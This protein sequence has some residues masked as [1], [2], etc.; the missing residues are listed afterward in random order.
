MPTIGGLGAISAID[1]TAQIPVQID[2]SNAYVTPSQ[3]VAAGGGGAGTITSV[4][5]D[6]GPAVTLD[7]ADVGA[8]SDP[9][10]LSGV[11]GLTGAEILTVE[12]GGTP[13]QA[14]TQ[15][16][17]NLAG[18]GSAVTSVNGQ[19]GPTVTLDAGDVGATPDPQLLSGVSGLTG[20]ERVAVLQGSGMVQATTAQ[21]AA[22]SGAVPATAAAGTVFA[23]PV[24]G[25]PAAPAFRDL[26]WN[27]DLPLYSSVSSTSGLDGDEH[28]LVEKGSTFL[29]TTVLALSRALLNFVNVFT[30]N[31]SVRTVTLTDAATVATDASLSNNFEVTL[32]GNRTLGN[33]TNLTRGMQLTWIVKQDGTGGR[34]L[35]YGN[36]F[37]WPS[38][39]VPT[40]AAGVNAVSIISAVYD[41]TGAG[42]SGPK[43]RAVAQT[44]FA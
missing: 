20:D 41:D 39:T 3:I 43:L 44:G 33:P 18:A 24:S 32:G 14:T 8:T 4:N 25:A 5:G 17:A 6:T 19:T 36:L 12:Q 23:G 31:Q 27:D 16:I 1:D 9:S 26:E 40:V 29:Q 38:G 30:K 15:Q 13:V 22:L 10:L 7:A 42:G 21:I 37:T 34:T 11:S 2:D 35:A 28:V